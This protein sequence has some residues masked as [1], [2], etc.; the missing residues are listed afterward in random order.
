[1]NN[2]RL[3]KVHQSAR[4]LLY[5]DSIVLYVPLAANPIAGLG[6]YAVTAG[7]AAAMEMAAKVF[8]ILI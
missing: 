8:M 4:Y 3:S 5:V 6:A 2:I 1:M 7:S